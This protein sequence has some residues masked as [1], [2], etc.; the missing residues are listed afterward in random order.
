MFWS[1]EMH[2]WLLH[3]ISTR[4]IA[5]PPKD[6][7]SLEQTE[8]LLFFHLSRKSGFFFWKALLPLYLTVLLA[9]AMFQFPVTDL[10]NRTNVVATY[11]LAEAAMLYV[12]GESLPKT[13]FLTCIDQ[14]IVLTMVTL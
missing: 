10:E 5:H 3:G 2:E 13:D 8:V 7:G 12:V 6:R 4:V 14:V 9:S 1:G 11:F